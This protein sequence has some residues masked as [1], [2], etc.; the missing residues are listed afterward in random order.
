MPEQM[1]IN[2][3]EN[4]HIQLPLAGMF[5]RSA[6]FL[7]DCA[8]QLFAAGALYF[9]VI[10]SIDG[11]GRV[12]GGY[13]L[14]DFLLG[15]LKIVLFTWIWAYHLYFEVYHGGR[16]PGKKAYGIRVVSRTGQAPGFF[17]SL[18]R[19]FLRI[20]DFLPFLFCAGVISTLITD[21]HQRLGD[22]FAGTLVIKE[23]IQV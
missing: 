21:R 17:P 3:P 14:R 23:N 20:A 8:I 18:L 4:H 13:L 6:A 7:Y 22:L 15:S 1:V 16:T 5:T 12:A 2:T 19:N 9:F 11:L 10:I